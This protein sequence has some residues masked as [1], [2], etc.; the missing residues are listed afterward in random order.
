MA[1]IVTQNSNRLKT[2]MNRGEYALLN[3]AQTICTVTETKPFAKMRIA[4]VVDINGSG[5]SDDLYRYALSAHF[6]VLISK[7]NRAF[8][9]IEFDGTGH[10]PRNDYKKAALCDWFGIPMVRVK[11]NHLSNRVFEDTAAGFLIWQLFCVDAF[12]EQCGNDPYEPYDPAWFLSVAGKD[13]S[14][15][16]AYVDRWRARLRRPLQEAGTR[17][18]PTVRD[19]YS[20]GL[21]QFGAFEF[22]YNRALEF[23]SAC[24]QVV[25]ENRVVWGEANFEIE[26]HGLE[27]RRAE[28]FCE[29]ATF[30]EGIAAEQMYREVISFLG[31]NGKAIGIEVIQAKI[32][33]WKAEEFRLRRGGYSA[34]SLNSLHF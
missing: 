28:L 10:D 24:G 7:N 1:G 30:V 12:L 21:V 4:D 16:F 13:R 34:T 9:V 32:S 20:Y 31:G 8:L 26:V 3:I 29:V 15:P 2:L 23:R 19:F 25:G 33:Q 18:D 14:W 17:L 27:G 6:D 5:I 22:T 11:E